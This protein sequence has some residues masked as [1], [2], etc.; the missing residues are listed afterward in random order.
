MV[1][2]FAYSVLCPGDVEITK[3]RNKS[4]LLKQI[5][6]IVQVVQSSFQTFQTWTSMNKLHWFLK[7]RAGSND[8][9]GLPWTV[10]SVALFESFGSF[11]FGSSA[12]V[13]SKMEFWRAAQFL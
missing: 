6:L 5:A 13:G 1:R 8:K 12:S 3:G 10:P 11:G 9:G 4:S 7:G 2:A